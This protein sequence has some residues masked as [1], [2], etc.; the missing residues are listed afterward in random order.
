MIH[1]TSAPVREILIRVTFDVPRFCPSLLRLHAGA[2]DSRVLID[3]VA[4]IAEVFV[5]Q[6]LNVVFT[7]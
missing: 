3:Q 4:Q 7:R 1:D 5:L 6:A 2:F